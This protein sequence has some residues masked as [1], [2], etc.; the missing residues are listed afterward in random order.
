MVDPPR[1]DAPRHRPE[2]PEAP[3]ESEE[4]PPSPFGVVPVIILLVLVAAG[5]FVAFRLKDVSTLQDCVM[6]GRKN[7]A[8]VDTSD[9]K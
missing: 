5:L 8:P 1:Q 2:P 7:C 4:D 9:L 3:P 6:S